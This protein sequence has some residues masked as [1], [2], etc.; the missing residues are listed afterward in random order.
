MRQTFVALALGLIVACSG[1]GAAGVASSPAVTA[2]EIGLLSQTPS[3]CTLTDTAQPSPGKTSTIKLVDSRKS[4]FNVHLWL[5]D[6][7]YQYPDWA[8]GFLVSHATLTAHAHIV[9]DTTVKPGSSSTLSYKFATGAYGILCVPLQNGSEYGVGYTAGPI[10]TS[11]LPQPHG[12]HGMAD[13]V[14]SGVVIYGGE[15]AGPRLGGVF[16]PELWKYDHTA[17]PTWVKKA[18]SEPSAKGDNLV[19]LD[20]CSRVLWL[21]ADG[22]DG[23]A[24]ELDVKAGQWRKTS[25]PAHVLFAMRAVYDSESKRVIAFG[26][27]HSVSHPVDETWAYDPATDTWTQMH[28]K[29]SPPARYWHAMAYDASADRVVVFGGLGDLDLVAFNDTWTYDFNRDTWTQVRTKSAPPGRHYHAMAYDAGGKRTVLF[30]GADLGEAPMG[31]TWLLDLNAGQW[32]AVQTSGPSARAWH[33]MAYDADQRVVVLIGGGETRGKFL[34][35]VWLFS[36]SAATWS[37]G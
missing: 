10:I 37:T 14:G 5:F 15:T 21:A 30:G 19:C 33:A 32:M 8:A 2:Q 9:A 23:H 16:L 34:N 27:A 4:G 17:T 25:A 1:P 7:G 12:Y 20:D 36:S 22:A 29:S 31:D 6:H 3:S 26:G 13:A 35:D 18:T 24:W 11:D 28:P